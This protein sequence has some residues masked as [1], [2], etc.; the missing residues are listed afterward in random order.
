MFTITWDTGIPLK[1]IDVVDILGTQA[2][3][4]KQISLNFTDE[5]IHFF[6]LI[7]PKNR[8]EC[9]FKYVISK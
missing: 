4:T 1:S 3:G 6:C 7:S 8:T 2:W 5:L 9:E